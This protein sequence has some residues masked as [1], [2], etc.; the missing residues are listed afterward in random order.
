MGLMI[1]L[2]EKNVNKALEITDYGYVFE[3]GRIVMEGTGQ[4]LLSNQG[5]RK[6]TLG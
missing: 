5:L 6:R 1:L 4:E 3:N 2:T